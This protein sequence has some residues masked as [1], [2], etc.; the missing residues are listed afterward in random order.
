MT[1]QEFA[2]F[3]KVEYAV[4][5]GLIRFLLS[6]NIVTVKGKRP[7]KNSNGKT[8]K[9]SILYNIPDQAVLIFRKAA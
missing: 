1:T 9:P 8:C 5:Y 3:L 6:R 4:A 2:D 7:N